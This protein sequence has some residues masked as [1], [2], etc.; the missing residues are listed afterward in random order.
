MFE[1]MF[2]ADS[3]VGVARRRTVGA[4][5][6]VLLFFLTER[7]ADR[8]NRK[9]A[10]WKAH[11]KTG[12]HEVCVRLVTNR[13]RKMLL[14]VRSCAV[15]PQRHPTIPLSNYTPPPAGEENAAGT[16]LSNRN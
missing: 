14:C 8:T 2:N 12:H 11:A 3:T 6:H 10:P 1:A 13:G 16:T 5:C 15:P 9:R 7:V 4:H